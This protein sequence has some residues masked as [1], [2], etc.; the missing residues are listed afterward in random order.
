MMLPERRKTNYVTPP[1]ALASCRDTFRITAERGHPSGA[2]WA[3]TL[4]EMEIS[5]QGV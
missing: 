1:L 2:Q 3:Q 4:S 5:V